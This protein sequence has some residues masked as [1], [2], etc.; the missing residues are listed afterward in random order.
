VNY[1]DANDGTC[2]IHW[3]AYS[4]RIDILELLLQ[5]GAD[6][7]HRDG[8]GFTPLHWACRR[9]RKEAT[10]FLIDRGADIEEQ[11]LDGSTPLHCVCFEG[12]QELALSLIDKGADRDHTNL[13]GFSPLQ[14]WHHRGGHWCASVAEN[15][16]IATKV[17][18][19]HPLAFD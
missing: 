11:T 14:L 16:E 10:H 8:Y 5:H 15:G 4:G 7:V 2:A 9:G 3:A 17:L 1:V 12:H 19:L 13:V 18:S 6:V